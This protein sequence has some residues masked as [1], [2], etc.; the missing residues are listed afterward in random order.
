[1]SQSKTICPHCGRSP[2]GRHSDWCARSQASR[3]ALDTW[4]AAASAPRGRWPGKYAQFSF[5]VAKPRRLRPNRTEIGEAFNPGVPMVKPPKPW[6]AGGVP[7]GPLTDP[8]S[9]VHGD[10]YELALQF[11][12][13]FIDQIRERG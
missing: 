11:K 6:T 1:M 12:R 9:P 3:R 10:K 2:G 4:A 5:E 7:R 13:D 8:K